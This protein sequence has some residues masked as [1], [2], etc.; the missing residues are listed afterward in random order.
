[1]PR[2]KVRKLSC[3]GE[4]SASRA[5]RSTE[6]SWP[7]ANPGSGRVARWRRR[8]ACDS[9][10]MP[11]PATLKVP[12]TSVSTA[13]FSTRSRSLSCTNCMRASKP[14]TVGMTGSR[15]YEAIGLTTWGPT[16][17][18]RRSMMTRTSGRRRAKPRT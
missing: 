7:T 16:T 3:S 2:P 6:P 9:I 14:S 12:A 17:L 15:K 5:W 8:T 13:C 10:R 18:A 4:K 1:M 11:S